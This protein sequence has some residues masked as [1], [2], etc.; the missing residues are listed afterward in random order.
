M[1]SCLVTVHWSLVHRC[2]GDMEHDVDIASWISCRG[3]APVAFADVGAFQ[4][5]LL[6]CEHQQTVDIACSN[7]CCA[8]GPVACLYFNAFNMF[9]W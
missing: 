6:P 3:E 2:S 5:L 1:N 7:G 8:C 9:L 4:M